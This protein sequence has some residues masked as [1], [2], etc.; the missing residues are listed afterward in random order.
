MKELYK[1]IHRVLSALRLASFDIDED[2]LR[3]LDEPIKTL[4]P[5]PLLVA[6]DISK[7]M[8]E[9]LSANFAQRT[10]QEFIKRL[11]ENGGIKS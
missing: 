11:K 4:V 2:H 7:K 1:T 10:I 5:A 6:H 3:G 8:G 9:E